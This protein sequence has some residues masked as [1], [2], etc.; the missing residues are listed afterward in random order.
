[1]NVKSRNIL[2]MINFFPPAGGG[3]VYRPLA[4]VKYLS[5][6]GWNVT[7]VTPRAGEF[8]ISDLGLE[9]QI[10]DT[11]RVVR[12][13]SLSAS[14]LLRALGRRGGGARSRRSTGAF[15][16]FRR[17]GECLLL[18]DT[19]VG[20]IP[21]AV[22]AASRLCE[23]ERFDA[24]YST[25]LPDSTHVAACRIARRFSIPWIADFRDPWISL[26]LRDP[27]TPL[28]RMLHRRWERAA[29]GAD[30]VLVTTE[31]HEKQLKTTYPAARIERI[32]N[33]YDE[34]EPCWF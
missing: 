27:P 1:M 18:P 26:Y 20:W 11:V 14:R 28:H 24:L 17:L 10:P 2:M 22:H 31:W 23:S 8:W 4:F 6:L 30:R 33:G 29:A 21:F 3:G 7:V 5:R 32:P 9:S 19:Y 12:T 16:F 25:S 15:G 34:E 13:T